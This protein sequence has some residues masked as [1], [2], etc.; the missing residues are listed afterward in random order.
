MKPSYTSFFVRIDNQGCC[1][2]GGGGGGG[3]NT[4]P[5]NK[6]SAK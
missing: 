6:L 1:K 4:P 3:C 2:M 5:E